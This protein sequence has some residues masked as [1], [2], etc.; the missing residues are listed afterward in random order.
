VVLAVP[1]NRT[2]GGASGARLFELPL[3]LGETVLLRRSSFTFGV[4]MLHMTAD[5]PVSRSCWH[6]QRRSVSGVQPILA[7]IDVI[8]A[9]RV[10]Y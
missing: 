5:W 4:A 8:A 9:H 7:A 2:A 10:W 6:T 3:V 1:A